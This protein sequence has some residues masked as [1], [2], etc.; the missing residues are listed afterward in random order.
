MYKIVNSKHACAYSQRVCEAGKET[1]KPVETEMIDLKRRRIQPSAAAVFSAGVVTS[2]EM[3]AQRLFPRVLYVP[4][5]SKY[6]FTQQH[7]LKSK[8]DKKKLSKQPSYPHREINNT[9]IDIKNS[10]HYE[11]PQDTNSYYRENRKYGVHYGRKRPRFKQKK[12]KERQ[13]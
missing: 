1:P 6:T 9:R 8:R 12:K 7:K 13:H 4:H 11:E 10:Q 5:F 3:N 2:G